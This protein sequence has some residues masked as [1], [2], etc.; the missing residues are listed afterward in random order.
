MDVLEV[1]GSADTILPMLATAMTTSAATS[2]SAAGP[3]QLSHAAIESKT[4]GQQQAYRRETTGQLVGQQATASGHQSQ[5]QHTTAPSE[6]T[7]EAHAAASAEQHSAG[8]HLN[9]PDQQPAGQ[10]QTASHADA[11]SSK[12]HQDDLGHDSAGQAQH[13]PENQAEPAGPHQAAPVADPGPDPSSAGQE[14]NKPDDIP[15]WLQPMAPLE[16]HGTCSPPGA[17]VDGKR[18]EQRQRQE[19]RH[20]HAC[21]MP[22]GIISLLC[23]NVM[24]F[25]CHMSSSSRHVKTGCLLTSCSLTTC[26]AVT[27]SCHQFHHSSLQFQLCTLTDNSC[28]GL[29]ASSDYNHYD[30]FH[31]SLQ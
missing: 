8:L 30:D 20:Q 25:L 3:G 7:H 11:S 22:A 27:S 9:A 15:I 12:Q 19:Q 17:H 13:A 18:L 29:L 6:Q 14:S 23:L 10:R 24:S 1:L 28:T 5:G 31:C 16:S 2:A 26:H 4:N 21:I